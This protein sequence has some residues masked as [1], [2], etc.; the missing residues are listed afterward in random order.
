MFFNLKKGKKVLHT[1]KDVLF[2]VGDH[3]SAIVPSSDLIC[4]LPAPKTSAVVANVLHVSGD[5]KSFVL[6]TPAQS[7]DVHS[8]AVE[9]KEELQAITA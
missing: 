8:D 4:A 2:K 7:F 3:V 6:P 9:G 1:S 5:V